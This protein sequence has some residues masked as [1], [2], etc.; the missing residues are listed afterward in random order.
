MASILDVFYNLQLHMAFQNST[1]GY[2][3]F[4]EVSRFQIPILNMQKGRRN[5]MLQ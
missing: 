5:C 1:D 3:N 2:S 4:A